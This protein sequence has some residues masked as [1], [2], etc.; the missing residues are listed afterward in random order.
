MIVKPSTGAGN[1]IDLVDDVHSDDVQI[2]AVVEGAANNQPSSVQFIQERRLPNLIQR[3]AR[4]RPNTSALGRST[5]N[6]RTT[7]ASRRVSTRTRTRGRVNRQQRSTSNLFRF[8]NSMVHSYDDDAINSVRRRN[9]FPMMDDE[10]EDYFPD[11]SEYEPDD[12]YGEDYEDMWSLIDGLGDAK[13]K[14]LPKTA[15][16]A[17]PQRSFNLN[18]RLET[19]TCTI[20]LSTFEQGNNLI[21][22]ACDHYF[23][24]ECAKRWLETN[25]R[26]PVCRERVVATISLI[27]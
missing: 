19:P 21:H 17:L 7:R 1:V 2:I 20:C 24:K 22:L 5:R 15:L 27:G 6:S 3:R 4:T 16:D 18:P 11:F 23:H 13:P 10:A 12:A 25:A 14:G 9:P 8:F 26:C